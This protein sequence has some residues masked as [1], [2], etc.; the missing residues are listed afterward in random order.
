MSSVGYVTEAPNR[1]E[2]N[3]SDVCLKCPGYC[4][5]IFSLR[6][7][8]TRLREMIKKGKINWAK[9][10]QRA[11]D[12][13]RRLPYYDSWQGF[14]YT[15]KKFDWVNKRCRVYHDRPYC[16]S[17][18]ICNEALENGKPPLKKEM[19]IGQVIGQKKKKR[20]K[21]VQWKHRN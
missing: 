6:H 19:Y 18:F 16:C 3:T 12:W 9:D 1:K 2:A 15:C 8:K 14:F 21:N 17:H 11:V 10:A 20:R 4:C 5:Q 7:S 13:F